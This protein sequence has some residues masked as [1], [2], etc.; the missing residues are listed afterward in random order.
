[1]KPVILGEAPGPRA[2]VPCRYPLSGDVGKRICALLS[3]SAFTHPLQNFA[4]PDQPAEWFLLSQYYELRN[5]LPEWPGR[6]GKGSG[7]P[8]VQAADAWSAIMP[9]LK[10]RKVV[11]LGARLRRLALMRDFFKWR[12]Y[13]D[14]PVAAIP[15]PSGL[16]RPYNAQE[17][18]LAAKRILLEAQKP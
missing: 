3:I 7:F 10:E 8:L 12:T 6:E 4:P 5:L 17:N 2:S 16:S 15:H 9:E 1:V 14:I 11:L 18:R 13:Q